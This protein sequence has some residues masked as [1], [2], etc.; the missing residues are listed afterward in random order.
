[1]V[2]SNA[3]AL[4]YNM[5]TSSTLTDLL[6]QLGALLQWHVL[7]ALKG[8]IVQGWQ[9]FQLIGAQPF[10]GLQLVLGGTSNHNQAC[11]QAQSQAHNVRRFG[12]TQR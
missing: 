3:L 4:F 8:Y 9:V 6:Q 12:L 1:M 2:V 7:Q 11:Q 10:G 5:Y